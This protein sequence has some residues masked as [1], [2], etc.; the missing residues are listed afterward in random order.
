MAKISGSKNKWIQAMEQSIEEKKMFEKFGFF[1]VDPSKD[2]F[3]DTIINADLQMEDVGL[4]K[5]AE[6][7]RVIAKELKAQQDNLKPFWR[8]TCGWESLKKVFFS[9]CRI[10]PHSIEW[11]KTYGNDR[12]NT[13]DEEHQVHVGTEQQYHLLLIWLVNNWHKSR[14]LSVKDAVKL[15]LNNGKEVY[16]EGWTET[17]RNALGKEDILSAIVLEDSK[18][19][20][21]YF[22]NLYTSLNIRD[23]VWVI[24][25]PRVEFFADRNE[26]RRGYPWLVFEL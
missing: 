9:D 18:G 25:I 10:M 16:G 6:E 23:T 24:H 4:N 26:Q 21:G 22:A 8:P 7:L 15:L 2:D 11:Y 3:F 13:G 14:E 19:K 1:Y 12:W 17:E 5:L 20:G